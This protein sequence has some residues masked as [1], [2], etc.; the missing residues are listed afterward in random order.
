MILSTEIKSREQDS[1][2]VGVM[3]DVGGSGERRLIENEGCLP[4]SSYLPK[5]NAGGLVLSE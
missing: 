2:S 1:R 5:S 4:L 3:V